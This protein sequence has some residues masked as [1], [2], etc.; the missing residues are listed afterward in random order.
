MN[1]ILKAILHKLADWLNGIIIGQIT[2]AVLE[3]FQR[4]GTINEFLIFYKLQE[5]NDLIGV[6]LDV[7]WWINFALLVFSVFWCMFRSKSATV[8][9]E[10]GHPNGANRPP[11]QL[12]A[13]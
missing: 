13:K 7:L 10:I 3:A 1:T 5:A 9:E 11:L 2:I 4:V 12:R 8:P 6:I